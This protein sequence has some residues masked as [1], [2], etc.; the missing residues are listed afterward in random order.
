MWQINAGTGEVHLVS[1]IIDQADR[2][3][4]AY[5]LGLDP[6]DDYLLFMNKNDLS[7]WSLD[8]I[9]SN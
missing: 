3:I 8:L 1:S 6:K 2:I 9:A 4:D 7:L 5:N